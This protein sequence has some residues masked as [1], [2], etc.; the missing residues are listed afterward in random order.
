MMTKTITS[1]SRKRI[2]TSAPPMMAPVLVPAR[3]TSNGG[4]NLQ[5]IKIVL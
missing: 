2:P 5:A 1:P 4:D 3:V